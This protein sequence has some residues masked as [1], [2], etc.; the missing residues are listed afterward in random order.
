MNE[1][2]KNS[3]RRTW[4]EWW[5][6]LNTTP[7]RDLIRGQLTGSLPADRKPLE[8]LLSFLK[9]RSSSPVQL[10]K[11]SSL[12]EAV[13]QSLLKIALASG[14]SR[15]AQAGYIE[16]MLQGLRLILRIPADQPLGDLPVELADRLSEAIPLRTLD[17]LHAPQVLLVHAL[18][19]ELSKL[20]ESVVR[21]TRLWKSERIDVAR[22][23]LNHCEDGLASGALPGQIIADFGDP[24]D[25]ARLIRS[26]KI[27]LRSWHWH[28][29]NRLLKGLG[30][31]LL[32][33][34][35]IYL[36]L[37]IR[38]LTAVPT[39]KRDFIGEID[40]RSE[41]IPQEEIAW[42]LYREASM[43]L[44]E[45]EVM[46]FW[47]KGIDLHQLAS[48]SHDW[49]LVVS[50]LERSQE[51]LSL[52]YQ[53]ASRPHLGFI[54]RDPSNR[55]W[56][57][58][59]HGKG[60]AEA[61]LA[62]THGAISG[63]LMPQ[64]HDL[65]RLHRLLRIEAAVAG[66]SQDR[67][68][69]LRATMALQLLGNQ[70]E[71]EAIG[72][73]HLVSFNVVKTDWN[74]IRQTLG[75]HPEMLTDRDLQ[76]LAHEVAAFRGGGRLTM[77]NFNHMFFEDL[78]QRFYTDDGQGDGRLNLL[79]FAPENLASGVSTKQDVSKLRQSLS[80]A[81]TLQGAAFSSISA[82]RK[83]M[84]QALREI[85]ALEDEEMSKPLWERSFDQPS[86]LKR[87]L[88]KWQSSLL[89]SVLYAPVLKVFAPF[90][91]S[92]DDWHPSRAAEYVTLHRDA[93]LAT[94]ALTAYHRRHGSWPASLDQL[95][96]EFLPAVP[97]D[98]FDGKPLKYKVVDGQPLLYSVGRNRKD[99]GGIPAADRSR[100]DEAPDGDIR[101]WPAD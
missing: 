95:S 1:S 10:L 62:S 44:I 63:V 91:K 61:Q 70:I 13:Q 20:I 98:R 46:E 84:R 5:C 3:M 40:Q 53:G 85:E 17:R 55:E 24:G 56:L 18:P 19:Q 92:S 76:N 90:F 50:H 28:L 31:L 23:L 80:V 33:G 75:S 14:R 4:S 99:D 43:K 64:V 82:S 36:W 21:K 101:F 89:E 9:R 67:G 51:S 8:S 32:V 57:E 7:L 93:T 16:E 39:I 58:S 6:L 69:W 86:P 45:E 71:E 83:E 81:S 87:S 100:G 54:Y 15:R 94:I 38:L 26:A 25:A 72:A 29:R 35:A 34:L 60:S 88:T 68:R 42:P 12:P 27:R 78:L 96:P 59:R 77:E 66:R 22:E 2:S 65:Y 37:I 47:K 73:I 49:A 97:V 11:D 79:N 74:Q 30:V 41:S 52:V 48:D